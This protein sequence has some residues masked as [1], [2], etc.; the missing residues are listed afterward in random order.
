MGAPYPETS[1]VSTSP[2]AYTEENTCT[3]PPSNHPSTQQIRTLLL[4]ERST[5]RSGKSIIEQELVELGDELFE[6]AED[7]E[8]SI[9]RPGGATREFSISILSD[10]D[11]TGVDEG[12]TRVAGVKSGNRRLSDTVLEAEVYGIT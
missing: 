9:F 2:N 1:S 8:R 3:L 5:I 12:L 11:N 4:S 7:E 6:L 10:K